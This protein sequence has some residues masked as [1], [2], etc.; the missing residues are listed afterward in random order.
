MRDAVEGLLKR[1]LV[2]AW[3]ILDHVAA[4]SVGLYRG[5]PILDLD[6]L[7]DSQCETDMNVVMTGTGGLV[8][9]QGTAERNS[10]SRQDLTQMLDLAGAGIA[11]LVDLQRQALADTGERGAE[12][13]GKG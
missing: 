6:Y 3:P 12:I 2:K 9:L 11:R 7:E 5:V 4:V 13:P 8:E 10:F 1:G